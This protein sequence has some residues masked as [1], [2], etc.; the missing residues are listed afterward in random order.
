[1]KYGF[2][3]GHRGEHRVEMMA[4]VLGVTRSGFYAWMRRGKAARQAADEHLRDLI[5]GVQKEVHYRYGSPRMTR[6]LRRRGHPVGHNHVARLMRQGALGARR[7][8]G[9]RVVDK[10]S[11]DRR[12]GRVPAVVR[13][14]GRCA[15]L[16]V[17]KDM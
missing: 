5:E 15:A 1:M 6:E 10:N 3:M 2:M 14:A 8:K 13:I 11:K 17:S 7:R 16:T 4:E 12:K 9:Y